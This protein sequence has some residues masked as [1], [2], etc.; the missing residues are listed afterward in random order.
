MLIYYF[1]SSLVRIRH[2]CCHALLNKRY[3]LTHFPP[4][5]YSTEI[6]GMG[7]THYGKKRGKAGKRE[8]NVCTLEGAVQNTTAAD[9]IRSD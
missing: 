8:P 6:R 7:I 3:S 5:S 2:Y 4:H 1:R 9:Q